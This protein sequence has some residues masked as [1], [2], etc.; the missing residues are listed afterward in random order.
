MNKAILIGNV[1]K[2]PEIRSFDNGG[3]VAGFTLATSEKY[4][5]KEGQKVEN[6]EWH[7]VKVFGKVA[8]VVEKYVTKGTKLMVEGQ[9]KTRSYDKDGVKMY[10]TEIVVAGFGDNIEMLGGGEKKHGPV[11]Q[12]VPAANVEPADDLPF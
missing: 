7:N 9:I 1:G 3:K 6:T 8:D 11:A 12:A 10:V 2:D 4:T 5:N